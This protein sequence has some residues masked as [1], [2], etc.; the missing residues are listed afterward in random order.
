MPSEANRHGREDERRRFRDVERA[1]ELQHPLLPHP[2]GI[3]SHS[4]EREAVGRDAADLS[5]PSAGKIFGVAPSGRN[6]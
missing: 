6:V 5:D 4:G 3:R 1:V 2:G